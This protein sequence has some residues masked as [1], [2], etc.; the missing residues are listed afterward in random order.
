MIIFQPESQLPIES[1]KKLITR[2]LV[3]EI[4]H[5]QEGFDPISHLLTGKGR[6]EAKTLEPDATEDKRTKTGRASSRTLGSLIDIY[7]AN[8]DVTRRQS[9]FSRECLGRI[10]SR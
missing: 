4:K 7:V 6:T 2:D 10:G 1:R 8:C 9:R 3:S 5:P